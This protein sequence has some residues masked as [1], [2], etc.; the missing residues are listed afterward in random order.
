MLFQALNAPV[1]VVFVVM[2]SFCYEHHIYLALP[3]AVAVMMTLTLIGHN[4]VAWLD[5][6]GE[7]TLNT[8]LL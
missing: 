7:P 4:E 8:R 2:R 6:V 5:E 1:I 3:P